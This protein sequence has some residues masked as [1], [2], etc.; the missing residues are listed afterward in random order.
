MTE[1]KEA[2]PYNCAIDLIPG[3]TASRG[4]LYSLSGPESPAMHKYIDESLQTGVIRPSASST[5]A[6]FFF[7][8][9]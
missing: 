9:N 6:G 4:S 7:V 5:V 8:G 3:S 1:V 2:R